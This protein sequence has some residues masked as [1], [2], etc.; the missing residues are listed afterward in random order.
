LI[1][2]EALNNCVKYSKASNVQISFH[3]KDH[4]FYLKIADD[5]AGINSFEDV[6]G[7]NGNGLKN[8]KSRATAMNAE[9]EF[10]SNKPHGVIIS[11]K[12]KLRK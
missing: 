7:L 9:I 3:Q 2:K 1:L 5:G 4:T 12:G 6:S 11:V 10:G 8:M